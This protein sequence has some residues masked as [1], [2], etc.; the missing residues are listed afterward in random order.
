MN[1]WDNK[2]KKSKKFGD[3]NKKIRLINNK[4]KLNKIIKKAKF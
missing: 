4:T 2:K 1:I 3:K